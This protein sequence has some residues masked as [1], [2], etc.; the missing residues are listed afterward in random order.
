[1]KV[2]SYQTFSVVKASRLI[3]KQQVEN[4]IREVIEDGETIDL[5]CSYMGSV[6][7]SITSKDDEITIDMSQ[8]GA[9][10]LERNTWDFTQLCLGEKLAIYDR[11]VELSD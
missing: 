7:H 6:I 2:I 5:D 8:F 3:L 4:A 11:L 9:G 10:I 1:M